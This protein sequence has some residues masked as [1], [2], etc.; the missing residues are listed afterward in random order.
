MAAA[1][2]LA[3]AGLAVVVLEPGAFLPAT[4]M[5]QRE[6]LMLP[7]LYWE[8]GGRTSVDRATHLHQGK[9]VGG[10]PS[11]K[12]QPRSSPRNL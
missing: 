8:A 9:G 6:E 12:Q 11:D 10:S 7:Q 3:E 1:R 4:A 5:T 2:V